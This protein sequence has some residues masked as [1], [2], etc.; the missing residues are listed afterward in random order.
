MLIRQAP[1]IR[2]SEIT[3]KDAYMNRRRFL[4]GMALAAGPGAASTFSGIPKSRLS[5]TEPPTPFKDVASYNNYYEFGTSKEQPAEYAKTLKTSPWSVS[6]EGA[7]DKPRKYDLDDLRKMA[8][9]EERIYR[10]RCVE[11]WSI[12][13]P[14]IGFPLAALLKAVEPTDKAKYVAFQTY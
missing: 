10:H 3:P 8:P 7:V 12:V 14:W 1:Q 11:A 4:A 9:L 2:S 5:T 13:V 6:V